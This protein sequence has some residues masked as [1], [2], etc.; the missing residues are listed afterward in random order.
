MA[1]SRCWAG[2]P[3]GALEAEGGSGPGRIGA[4]FEDDEIEAPGGVVRAAAEGEDT[5]VGVGAVPGIDLDPLVVE[6][7]VVVN[8]GVG[9]DAELIDIA[10]KAV[11]PPTRVATRGR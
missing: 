4:D 10:R 11:A 5:L 7:E 3:A 8:E 9:R 1:A 2:F 6:V